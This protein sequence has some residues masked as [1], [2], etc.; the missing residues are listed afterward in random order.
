MA[1]AVHPLRKNKEGQPFPLA[2]TMRYGA[3]QSLFLA[4]DSTWRWSYGDPAESAFHR[5]WGRVIQHMAQN[6]ML[7][8]TGRASVSTDRTEYGLG[9]RVFVLANVMDSS[10][11]PLNRTR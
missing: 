11:N 7:G 5:F 10:F 6:R 2:V 3:G 8:G 9:D 1:L 4:F